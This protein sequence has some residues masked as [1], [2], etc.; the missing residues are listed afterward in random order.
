MKNIE[1]CLCWHKVQSFF[2][3]FQISTARLLNILSLGLLMQSLPA[4]AIYQ[5]QP[6]TKDELPYVVSIQRI[7]EDN[8]VDGHNCT[9]S[10]IAPRFVLTAAHCLNSQ[11]KL[12]SKVLVNI[13]NLETEVGLFF[14]IKHII[15]H[16][17]YRDSVGGIGS[18]DDIMLLELTE[19]V[20]LP[21]VKLA[22][23]PLSHYVNPGASLT[24]TGWGL[25]D[26]GYTRSTFLKKAQI[27][28]MNEQE[29]LQIWPD[30]AN[31][32]FGTRG[33]DG[34]TC[35]GDSGGPVLLMEQEQL[36][37]VGITKAGVNQCSKLRTVSTRVEPYL[38]WIEKEQRLSFPRTDVIDTAIVG[39]AQQHRIEIKNYYH[40][41]LPLNDFS[42][43]AV[44]QTAFIGEIDIMEDNCSGQ[45]LPPEQI[46]TIDLSVTL[47]ES[48]FAQLKFSSPTSSEMFPSISGLLSYRGVDVEDVSPFIHQGINNDKLTFLGDFSDKW[49]TRSDNN[50]ADGLVAALPLASRDNAHLIVK[51]ADK[52]K[53]MLK[54]AIEN[55]SNPVY[56]SA[57][58]FTLNN[59]V[60]PISATNSF[61]YEG[62]TGGF[63][64]IEI[65]FTAEQSQLVLNF[66]S[67]SKNST[68]LL[69]QFDFIAET[70]PEPEPTPEPKK[71]SSNGGSS[72]HLLLLLAL[73]ILIFR[74]KNADN[75]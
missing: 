38:E 73:A 56:D 4:Y 51:I 66:W 15:P 59:K 18:A 44:D 17:N 72:E 63:I 13:S 47:A 64:N 42:F 11:D 2:R 61:V 30:I 24:V 31:S 5:G 8:T 71:S 46:C 74:F 35:K 43:S 54:L 68:L 6:V 55:L 40:E 36:I 70:L 23:F 65:P 19:P 41:N 52:G 21:L 14:D 20:N 1:L 53:L 33:I 25:T 32:H 26:D 50:T 22:Q 7:R 34:D 37:Q 27:E 75:V 3:P 60:V 67:G 57:L 29:S 39:Q 9:G 69:E 45:N 12:D 62:A 28:L 16:P 10:L 49:Q 58:V 48:G